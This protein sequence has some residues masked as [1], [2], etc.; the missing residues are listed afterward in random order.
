[1][2][3]YLLGES[4]VSVKLF[5]NNT[6]KVLSVIIIGSII[7]FVGLEYESLW[8]DEIA[9][10]N[11]VQGSFAEMF[12]RIQSDV[13][14]PLYYIFL[15]FWCKVFGFTEI[16]LRALSALVS[17]MTLVVFY[18]FNKK[19]LSVRIAF[20][21]LLFLTFSEIHVWYAQEARSYSLFVLVCILSYFG[22]LRL[23]GQNGRNG[24]FLYVIA[25]TAMVYTHVFGGIYFAIQVLLSLLL[26]SLMV[27]IRL[28]LIYMHILVVVFYLPWVGYGYSQVADVA[29]GYWIPM[30]SWKALI[31]L[32]ISFAGGKIEFILISF[33][34]FMFVWASFRNRSHE[35]RQLPNDK[36][37]T[38]L[39]WAILPALLSYVLS[40]IVVPVFLTRTL[41]PSSVAGISILALCIDYLMRTKY[42]R[43]VYGV[44]WLWIAM[45][46]YTIHNSFQTDEKEQ[47]RTL[48]EDLKKDQSQG[49]TVLVHASFCTSAI[50]YYYP[51]ARLQ[52]FPEGKID[53]VPSDTIAL[54]SLL[55]K[56]E[57]VRLVYSHSR[58]EDG[59]VEDA[60]KKRGYS[61]VR[62]AHYVGVESLIYE[63]Q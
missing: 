7:R 52:G 15:H 23:L 34:F 28:K 16:S 59:L 60:L 35:S 36:M 47:W 55:N 1:M 31:R 10:V 53:I 11:I 43:L 9:S 49:T 41:L 50:Q 4:S 62:E 6:W 58:D 51:E 29:S 39:T 20:L 38:L 32:W 57:R 46:V 22:Y 25:T 17:S 24:G 21:A 44:V 3:T 26:P 12:H 56:S 45:S 63:K 27:K 14:P 5:D 18:K 40:K 2:K 19:V 30:P 8:L 33:I 54:H 61:K 48:A 42:K 13:H 37:V